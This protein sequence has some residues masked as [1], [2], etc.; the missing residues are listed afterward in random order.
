MWL[1]KDHRGLMLFVGAKP[2]KYNGIYI[3]IHPPVAKIPEDVVEFKV[4]EPVS[5]KIVPYE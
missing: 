3:S 1:V 2:E 4:I 5:V